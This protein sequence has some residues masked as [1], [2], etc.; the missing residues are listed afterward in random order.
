MPKRLLIATLTA[1]SFLLL[2]AV[3]QHEGNTAMAEVDPELRDL[4]E[5]LYAAQCASCHMAG[6][7]GAPPAFPA[8]RDNEALEDLEMIV[9]NVHRGQG[10]MPAFPNLD[11]EELAGIATFVRNAWDNAFGGANVDE[12]EAILA[13]IDAPMERLAVWEG[14]YTQEQADRGRRVFVTHCAQCHGERGDGAGTGADM[15]P[16]PSIVG[17]NLFRDWGGQSVFSLFEITR[18]TM[19]QINPNSLSPEAYADS[20]AYVFAL[21]GLPAGE[22]ELPAEREVLETIVIEPQP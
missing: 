1:A 15:P 22:R 17:R 19:P 16:S 3:A 8:L 14:V 21:S 11:A 20:L 12:V 2:V 5:A 4:G 9:V 13:A 6:G 18:T 10:A 7:G